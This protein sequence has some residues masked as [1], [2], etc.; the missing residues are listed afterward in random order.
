VF[1]GFFRFLV[2]M[3]FCFL[4]AFGSSNFFAFLYTFTSK[5]FFIFLILCLS[6]MIITSFGDGPFRVVFNC[7]DH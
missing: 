7:D 5:F 6:V 3:F 2:E 1:F 4:L